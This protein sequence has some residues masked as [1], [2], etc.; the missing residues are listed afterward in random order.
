MNK[1]GGNAGSSGNNTCD[2][3]KKSKKVNPL[4]FLQ[5][6]LKG[7]DEVTMQAFRNTTS[8]EDMV[9]L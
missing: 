5:I 8:Q 9:N 4:D 6:I 3:L 1:D 7:A 2:K